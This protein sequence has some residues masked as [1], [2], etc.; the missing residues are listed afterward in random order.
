MLPP[1]VAARRSK[2][3]FSPVLCGRVKRQLDGIRAMFLSPT[4]ASERY[5]SQDEARRALAAFQAVPEPSFQLTWGVWGI[6]TLE[7]WLRR[8]SRY[9]AAAFVEA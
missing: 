7:A 8:L 1:A 9:T 6:A 3:E 4:W 5:V 2:A